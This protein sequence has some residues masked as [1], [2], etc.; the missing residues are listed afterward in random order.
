MMRKAGLL[1]LVLLLVVTAGCGRRVEQPAP[2]AAGPYPM[3]VQD[4]AGRQVEIA[5][6]PQRIVSLL[7]SLTETLFA[8]GLGE[9]V[10]GVTNFCNYPA[11]AEGKERVGGLR[12]LNAEKILALE[13]DVV[14]S[15][16]M[17]GAQEVLQTLETAGVTVVVFD[18]ATMEDIGR[19]I[20]S[21]G[22]LAGVVE[23]GEELAGGIAAGKQEMTARVGAVAGEKPRVFMLLD[24]ENIWTVGD[25]EYMSEMIAAAGGVNAASGQG[26]GWLQLSEEKLF[27]LDPDVIIATFPMR[28]QLLARP[29][30]QALQAVRN[31][32][33]Y[34]ADG[35]LVSRPG[36]RV[37]LGLEELH[38]V[39]YGQ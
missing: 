9:R 10:V 17:K 21:V 36:P 2:P 24:T 5:A 37:L 31:G 13:P 29:G 23:K 20:R 15:G 6:E 22:K 25:G 19:V 28:E 30:W 35:D 11:E 7:P 18:P 39:F 3:V 16:Q 12:D 4:D 38:R 32:R 8:L 27:E 34:D 33:V 14:L 26:E 1:M